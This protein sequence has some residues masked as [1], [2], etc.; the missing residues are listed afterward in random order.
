MA[1]TINTSLVGKTFY[2]YALN[3]IDIT[4]NKAY[5]R[6]QLKAQEQ[7]VFSSTYYA[8]GGSV[9][10]RNLSS[11]FEAVMDQLGYPYLVFT[12]IA[13]DD[14]QEQ[15]M[16]FSVLYCRDRIIDIPASDFLN[17]YF[18]TTNL[19][20]L[21]TMHNDERLYFYISNNSSYNNVMLDFSTVVRLPDGSIVDYTYIGQQRVG[22]GLVFITVSAAGV[23][24]RVR[25]VYAGC[26]LLYFKVTHGNHVCRFYVQHC[27]SA[28]VFQFRNNFGCQEFVAF[29][30]VTTSKLESE[31][32]EAK[33]NGRLSHY[34]VRHSRTYD[35]ETASLLASQM[36]WLEQ[37]VT[38]KMIMKIDSNVIEHVLIK[39]YDFEQSDAPGVENK[40]SFTWQFADGRQTPYRVSL[41]TNT[42]TKPF[43][44][45]F[46]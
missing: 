20:R 39:D 31:F 26:T 18:L 36:T 42:F 10:V 25:N 17:N 5:V 12:L 33:V 28:E 46:A 37:F 7:V 22:S 14:S 41:Y 8:V 34:D 38:S 45:T 13:N 35:V 3:E 40:L 43:N 30:A 27:P 44:E 1:L 11:L 16:P 19:C 23:Q 29:P 32:S 4:T 21:T 24:E 9:C 2:S 6:V 15:T